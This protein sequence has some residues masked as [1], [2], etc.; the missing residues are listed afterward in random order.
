M[1]KSLAASGGESVQ[2][3]YANLDTL[4][5][6]LNK[7]AEKFPK[8]LGKVAVR[9]SI[10]KCLP[11]VGAIIDMCARYLR[12]DF[13]KDAET[14]YSAIDDIN[15]SH[16]KLDSDLEDAKKRLDDYL[17]SKNQSNQWRL[18]DGT[19]SLKT[20]YKNFHA[21]LE[22]AG[23]AVNNFQKLHYKNIEEIGKI[24][25]SLWKNASNGE[26]AAQYSQL[27]KE[28]DKVSVPDTGRSGYGNLTNR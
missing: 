21:T 11:Y 28:L 17:K 1:N 20:S 23:S 3:A 9:S 18:V 25:D 22:K 7:L 19:N 13:I 10:V 27:I 24:A 5:A 16:H 2:K 12:D 8:Q 14:L 26:I 6:V 4:V 15:N